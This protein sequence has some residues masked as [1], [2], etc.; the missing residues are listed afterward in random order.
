MTKKR[1]RELEEDELSDVL[2]G[3]TIKEI[4]SGCNY[5]LQAKGKGTTN[6][7][8]NCFYYHK[9]EKNK[10]VCTNPA[11]AEPIGL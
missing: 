9:D 1:R 8:Q 2:G 4:S 6:D 11:K 5:F 7:C 3:F 10:D